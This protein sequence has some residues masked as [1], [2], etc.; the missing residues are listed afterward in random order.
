MG[1]GSLEPGGMAT[2]AQIATILLQY[3][4]NK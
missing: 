1:D 2:R 3:E 4:K